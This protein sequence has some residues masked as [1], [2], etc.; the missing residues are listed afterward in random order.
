MAVALVER[1][2]LGR[3]GRHWRIEPFNELGE[4]FDD[5]G[6]VVVGMLADE[7]DHLAIAVG[8]LSVVAAHLVHHSEPIPAVVHVGEADQQVACG[9]LGLVELGG[10]DELHH[11]IGGGIELV[12]MGVFLLGHPEARGDLCHQFIAGRRCAAAGSWRWAAARS[13]RRARAST[14]AARSAAAS[15]ARQHFLYLLPLPQGQGSLRPGF[16]LGL[17]MVVGTVEAGED[18]SLYRD[19][20]ADATFHQLLLACD[21]DLADA[22]RAGRCA[23]CG[24][25]LHSACYPRKPRGRPCRLG[26]E[27]DRRFSFCCAV[28]GCR[29]R[30]TPPSLRFLGRKVYLAAIV[31]LV[32]ILRHG[33]T[34]SRM[35][36]LSQAVGV[37][38]RTVERWRRWWR[39]RFTSTPFWRV[40]RATF[41]PPIDHE[42]V[43]ASLLERFTGDNADR[44]IALLRFIGPVTGGRVHV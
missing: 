2:R 11:G 30:A 32:A 7:F 1:E 17:A 5:G 12:L 24:G 22:A 9:R 10:A 16:D 36:R 28:D 41:M 40:A 23:L 33:V 19:L 42:R 21:A 29:S 25:A 18:A 44:L 35:E 6:V 20:L 14:R 43:P 39:E 38:R 4:L 31:V 37:D 27:H 3:S 15:L 13:S 8:R 26:P 34:T